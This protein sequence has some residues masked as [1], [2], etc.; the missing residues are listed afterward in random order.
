MTFYTVDTP[1]L[2]TVREFLLKQTKL[3]CLT[4]GEL[5]EH[6]KDMFDTVKVLKCLEYQLDLAMSQSVPCQLPLTC[7]VWVESV[8]DEVYQ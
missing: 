2:S 1:D 3:K 4:F 8:L 5:R 6:T 7:A